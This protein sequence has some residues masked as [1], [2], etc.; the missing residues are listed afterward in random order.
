MVVHAWSPPPPCLWLHRALIRFCWLHANLFAGSEG[1][2]LSLGSFRLALISTHPHLQPTKGKWFACRSGSID[3][4]GWW[5]YASIPR[6]LLWLRLFLQL[7]E[8]CSTWI[9]WSLRSYFLLRYQTG[10]G[11]GKLLAAFLITLVIRRMH[12][13]GLFLLTIYFLLIV[14]RSCLHVLPSK[15]VT[16]AVGSGVTNDHLP[17]SQQLN[18]PRY[19]HY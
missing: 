5:K 2:S 11:Q 6:L 10:K 1:R 13:I 14:T 9:Y 7:H 17:I 15:V 19:S 12:V 18:Y 4:A 16:A 3:P 8:T